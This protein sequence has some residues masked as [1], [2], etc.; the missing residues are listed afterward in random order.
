LSADHQ[1]KAAE[2]IPKNEPKAEIEDRSTSNFHED[3][4]QF[5]DSLVLLDWCKLK[6]KN[7]LIIYYEKFAIFYTQIIPILIWKLISKAYAQPEQ[8]PKVDSDI[9]G[10]VFGRLMGQPVGVFVS[11]LQLME[12]NPRVI[13]K[14]NPAH[15]F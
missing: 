4:P 14:M 9:Y 12:I 6:K 5:D 2:F 8:C 3:E 7:N 10:R 15:M 1:Q 11:R 13:S